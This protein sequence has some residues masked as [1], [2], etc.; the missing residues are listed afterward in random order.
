[1]LS[2]LRWGP[3][4]VL[5]VRVLVRW[6]PQAFAIA[7]L[8]DRLGRALGH[9]DPYFWRRG[10]MYIGYFHP[11]DRWPFPQIAAGPDPRALNGPLVLV[12]P[13]VGAVEGV[14]ALLARLPG[15]VISLVDR[16]WPPQ[17]K[18]RTISLSGGEW[19]RVAALKQ[20]ADTLKSGGFVFL[21][22]D[23]MGNAR[24]ETE[25]LGETVSWTRGAFELA[26]LTG[27]P[28]LPVLTLW[29]GRKLEIV[30]GELIFPS[31]AATMAGSLATWL[32]SYASEDPALVKEL[33]A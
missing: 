13:H 2:F 24:V 7:S 21:V 32:E 28:M 33:R 17:R 10:V 22:A 15:E 5:L 27:S 23:G 3:L 6:P 20:A 8:L 25:L 4:R 31:D 26:R 18:V 29:R 12:G 11:S 19:Q 16:E 14:G 30:T 1:M 9:G